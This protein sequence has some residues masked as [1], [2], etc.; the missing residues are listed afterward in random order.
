VV[1]T[2][3]VL[4]SPYFT[5]RG[6]LSDQALKAE[7]NYTM[8]ARNWQ[9]AQLEVQDHRLRRKTLGS[10]RPCIAMPRNLRPCW[11]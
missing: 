1:L 3:C 2:E 7:T 8:I 6:M 11:R 9:L 5:H 4:L 10:R